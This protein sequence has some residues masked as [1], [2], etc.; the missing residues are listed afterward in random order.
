MRQGKN[1]MS[2]AGKEQ[3]VRGRERTK[4]IRQGKNKMYETGKEQN[5]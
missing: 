5:V 4:C 1:K 2:E 3:N